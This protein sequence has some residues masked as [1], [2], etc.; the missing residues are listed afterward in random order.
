MEVK[1]IIPS[2]KRWDRVSTVSAVD[3]AILCV[4]ESQEKLYRACNKGIEVVTHPD[5]VVGLARKRDWIIKHF[6][7]VF[8]LDDDI[9]SLKRTYQE[10]GESS[11]IDA[12]DAYDVIQVA[13]NACK[14]AGFFLFGFSMS[15]TP[16]QYDPFKPIKMGGY[17]TGCA[18]GVLS[19]SKL[20]YNPDIVCNEDYWIS[21]LNAYYHRGGWKDNRFCF[22]QRDTF[23]NRGGLSEFRNLDSEEQDFKLLQ[24]TFGADVVTLRKQKGKGHAF[25]KTLKFPFL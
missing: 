25:Q 13:A 21:C 23:K 20:W 4:A 9:D 12:A 1:V 24:R 15:A 3:G 10:A 19:G 8:M 11:H 17:F 2:H 18:H 7:N 6:E 14:D 5:S 16:I 22:V